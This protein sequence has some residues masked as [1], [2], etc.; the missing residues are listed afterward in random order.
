MQRNATQQSNRGPRLSERVWLDTRKLDAAA[1]APALKQNE[2]ILKRVEALLRERETIHNLSVARAIEETGITKA[3]VIERLRT[4]VDRAMQQVQAVGPNGEVGDFK[5]DGAV[6]NR[7]LELLGKELGMF[8][9]RGDTKS[10]LRIISAEP[11][12]PDEW[13]ARHGDVGDEGK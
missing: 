6:A 5:Y 7:A 8:V 9:D 4:N 10:V 13:I 2:A 1:G 11:L 12:T 3:W